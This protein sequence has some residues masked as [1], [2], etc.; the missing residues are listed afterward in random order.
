MSHEW[1][2]PLNAIVGYSEV[3]K[4]GRRPGGHPAPMPD[5]GIGSQART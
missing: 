2:T 4:E 1:R 3:M 5:S